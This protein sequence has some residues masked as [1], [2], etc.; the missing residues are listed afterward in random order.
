MKPD[1]QHELIAS[2]QHSSAGWALF[3]PEDR[4]ATANE[5]GRA[6]LG[7]AANAHPTW[8]QLMR[9]CHRHRRG[10]AIDTNDIDGWV[11][12]VRSKFRSQPVRC[13]ESDL[14]DGRWMW[15]TETTRPDGWVLVLL[16]DITPLKQNEATLRRARD[17]ALIAAMTDP[18]TRLYNRRYIFKRLDDLLCSTQQM[19][20]P[21]AVAMLDLDHFK[22]VNDLHG[23]AV[24][25]GVL[26]H[27]AQQLQTQLRPLDAVGRIGGEEFLIVLPNADAAGALPVLERLRLRI[28][29]ARSQPPLPYTFSAGVAAVARGES[30]ADVVRRADDALYAAKTAGRDQLAIAA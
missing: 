17:T 1:L 23:H 18:L 27:F 15:V 24:G 20:I 4:L 21:L 19:R 7:V 2:L 9:D 13:F 10:V 5:A 30:A 25:D 26:Q 28:G 11:A 14:V 6:A 12:R 16:V 3:D 29:D 8:E 22:R